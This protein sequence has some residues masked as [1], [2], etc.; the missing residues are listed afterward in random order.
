MEPFTLGEKS[1]IAAPEAATDNQGSQ[2]PGD[3]KPARRDGRLC[4]AIT[5]R[6]LCQPTSGVWLTFQISFNYFNYILY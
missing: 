5:A 3:N 2:D 4:V 1:N 6:V